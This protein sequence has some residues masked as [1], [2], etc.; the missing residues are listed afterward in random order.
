MGLGLHPAEQ[1]AYLDMLVEWRGRKPAAGSTAVGGRR[2]L[3][4]I[5]GDMHFSVNTSVRRGG[6]PVLRQAITSAISN[7]P[8]FWFQFYLFRCLMG[9]CPGNKHGGYTWSCVSVTLAKLSL[10]RSLA[11]RCLPRRSLVGW[12]GRGCHTGTVR[13]RHSDYFPA[14]NYA[15]VVL[16][17]EQ[18]LVD[19]RVERS[20]WVCCN[21][22]GC[23][24]C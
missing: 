20:R 3:L 4:L 15:V 12:R 22:R 11:K 1:A 13:G 7:K 10:A 23:C 5:G 24:Y 2:D 17:G 19:H 14:Q 18:G 9:C 21:Y 8:P 6:E 16:D